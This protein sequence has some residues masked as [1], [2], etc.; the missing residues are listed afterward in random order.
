MPMV[1][2]F[3]FEASFSLMFAE[4]NIDKDD[5][6][7]VCGHCF[8]SIS[9]LNQVLFALNEEYCIN[10]KKAVRMIDGFIIKSKDYKSRIDEIITLLSA[11]R[12]TTREGINMLK[13]LI[14]ETKILLSNC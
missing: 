9:C 4:D 7:Y 2:Y 14:S 13:E 8:R 12:D 11:D 1:Q 3:M 10:E 6:Y 5:I